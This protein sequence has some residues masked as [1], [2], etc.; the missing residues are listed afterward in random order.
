MADLAVNRSSG[1]EQLVPR[2]N[3]DDI[4]HGAPLAN[5][6]VDVPMYVHV[7]APCENMEYVEIQYWFF[8][9]YNGA[10]T[11]AFGFDGKKCDCPNPLFCA[12]ERKYRNFEWPEFSTHHGDWEYITVR[13][14]A[15]LK[16]DAVYFNG[17]RKWIVN[18]KV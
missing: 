6:N 8:H 3:F 17:P 18:K 4:I 2:P 13:L 9:A 10:Q 11:F 12:D 15:A 7:R 1:V 14:D 5:G 16:V